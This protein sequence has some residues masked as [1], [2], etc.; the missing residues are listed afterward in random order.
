MGAP[1][2]IDAALDLAR[3]PALANSNV[4]PP[5]P[6]DVLDVMQIAA[7]SPEAC[8]AAAMA[9]GVPER[10]LIEAARF[11]L[12]QTLFRPDADCYRV[13][14]LQQH[15][16]HASARIHMRWLLQWQHPDRN[17][18]WDAVY[19]KRI[20]KAWREVS[21]GS[22][23]AGNFGPTT[24]EAESRGQIGRGNNRARRFS[25]PVRLPWIER[26]NENVSA[27]NRKNSYR[28]FPTRAMKIVAT[29]VIVL[30]LLGLTKLASG[31][32][33]TSSELS[34]PC[35]DRRSAVDCTW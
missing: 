12:Q 30:L 21:N 14:G 9:T 19:A 2:A 8:T 18:G 35:G 34:V 6:A 1:R 32:S 20:I 5:L 7:E 27:R 3:I 17:G 24:G 31:R 23:A 13:L 22:S 33:S 29:L 26:P 15:A 11:Y 25:A 10:V 16:S 28:R 4:T